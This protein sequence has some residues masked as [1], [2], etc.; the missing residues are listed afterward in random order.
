M[1]DVLIPS[2]HKADQQMRQLKPGFAWQQFV[3][4]SMRVI[5]KQDFAT[6]F[7]NNRKAVEGSMADWE[8]RIAAYIQ[9]RVPQLGMTVV[10]I[11]AQ[12]IEEPDESKIIE[13]CIWESHNCVFVWS[14]WANLLGPLPEGIVEPG[15]SLPL[16]AF[17]PR[18]C[19][20][21]GGVTNIIDARHLSA[22]EQAWT[23]D[24]LSKR[25]LIE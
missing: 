25:G 12:L 4:T 9:R 18:D 20:M 19:Q 8:Q 17:W 6:E 21:M 14:I 24:D 10:D 11:S 23:Q 2:R 3:V 1:G 13:I 5:S 16:T 22:R 7:D 15:R